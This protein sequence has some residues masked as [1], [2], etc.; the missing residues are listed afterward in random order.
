M[1]ESF[2]IKR[3]QFHLHSFHEKLI[4]S[5][6]HA[7]DNKLV[8]VGEALYRNDARTPLFQLQGLARIE[9]RAGKNPG[10]GKRWA[11]SFKILE[12]N[13]G[14]YDFWTS[15]QESNQHWKFQP[16]MHDFL[17]LKK[18]FYLGLIEN[19][20]I[21]QGWI[22]TE[23]EIAK[24]SERAPQQ[25]LKELK[26]AHWYK[27]EKE[28]RVLAKFFR[29]ET[30]EIDEKIRN[31]EINLNDIEHGVHE[32][33]RQLRWLGIYSSALLGKV[34]FSPAGRNDKL[35]HYV[36]KERSNYRFNLLPSLQPG[37]N[38]LSFLRGGFFALS[39]LIEQ[40]GKLKDPALATE[41]IMKISKGLGINTSLVR[42]RMGQ[43]YFTS[44]RALKEAGGLIKHMLLKERILLHIA[45]H[46]DQQI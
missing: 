19:N 12:D 20:L 27:K 3:Y 13:L 38:P 6:R 25:F 17:T 14:T 10:K 4:L 2:S 5:L 39:V 36:T 35:G 23:N 18:G 7:Q 21:T 29:D 46:F 30:L 32:L 8:H 40:L 28:T 33:R 34:Q 31:K 43:D 37:E 16:S 26:K 42:S 44:S 24:P 41:E 1:A 22:E 11:E 45:E 15:L 9:S